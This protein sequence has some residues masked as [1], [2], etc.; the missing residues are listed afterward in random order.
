MNSYRVENQF[1][2]G[3]WKDVLQQWLWK[4]ERRVAAVVVDAL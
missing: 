3:N 1:V 2:C 4:L